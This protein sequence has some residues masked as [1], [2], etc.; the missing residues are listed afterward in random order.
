MRCRLQLQVGPPLVVR[1][2]V[3]EVAGLGGPV[4]GGRAAGSHSDL[5]EADGGQGQR[6]RQLSGSALGR[7]GTGPGRLGQPPAGQLAHRLKFHRGLLR[8]HPASRLQNPD[9][10]VIGQLAHPAGGLP[11]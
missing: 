9:E 7:P 2:D 3:V 8:L 10:L 1:D 5:G 6:G 4:A 11:G